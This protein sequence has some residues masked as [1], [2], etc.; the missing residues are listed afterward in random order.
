MIARRGLENLKQSVAPRLFTPH[1]GEMARLIASE[2][3]MQNLSRSEL[4]R[5]FAEKFTNVTLL[6]K[7]A[8]TVIAADGRPLFFNTTGHPGMASG[9][10]GDVLSGLCAALVAQG[11]GLP[12]AACLG[13]WLSG[14]AAEIAVSDGHGSQESLCAGDVAGCLGAA[15]ADVRRLAF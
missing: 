13:A 6:L 8:R 11:S 3:A 15:F 10:M 4:A 5:T 7:G 9:G 12:E 2:S 14:R 1:P